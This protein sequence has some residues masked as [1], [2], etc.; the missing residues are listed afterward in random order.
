MSHNALV[1]RQ[2]L[3]SL[4]SAISDAHLGVQLACTKVYGMMTYNDPIG[5]EVFTEVGAA[6]ATLR[7]AVSKLETFLLTLSEAT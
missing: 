2:T 1:D 7:L 4:S 5:D 3:F 6:L